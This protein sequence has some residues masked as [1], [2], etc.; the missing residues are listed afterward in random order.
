MKRG[1][2]CAGK[3]RIEERKKGRKEEMEGRKMERVREEG[4]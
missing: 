2:V 1:G 4:M 3:E